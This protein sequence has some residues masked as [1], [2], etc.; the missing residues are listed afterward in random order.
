MTDSQNGQERRF[1]VPKFETIKKVNKLVYLAD[2]KELMV[3]A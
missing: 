3:R 2:E 1:A